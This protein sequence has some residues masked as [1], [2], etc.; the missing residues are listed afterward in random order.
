MKEDIWNIQWQKC[1]LEDDQHAFE[2]LFTHF[3]VSLVRFA[4]DYVGEKASAEEIVS[5][6]FVRLWNNRSRQDPIRNIGTYL[7]ISVRNQSLNYLKKFSRMRLV[8]DPENFCHRLT[9]S[10]DPACAMEWK[11]LLFRLDKAV[12]ALPP[13]CKAVFKLV[14]EEGFRHKEV[15]EILS[16]SPRTVETQ[17][18]RAMSK[19]Q[20]VLDNSP[21]SAPRRFRNNELRSMLLL[22][23]SLF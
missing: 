10:H 12:E 6:V 11:E 13:Q 22:F 14:R 2:R 1:C 21:S 3:Y 19:L 4:A 5:D 18:L 20:D 8:A 16:I 9:D 17:L 7:F 15:A 23:G